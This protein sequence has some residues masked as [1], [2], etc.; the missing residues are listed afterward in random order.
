MDL[1]FA[2]RQVVQVS[3]KEIKRGQIGRGTRRTHMSLTYSIQHPIEGAHKEELLKS[4]D[5]Y[6]Q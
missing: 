6:Y 3:L 4:Q 5:D 2:I 1:F